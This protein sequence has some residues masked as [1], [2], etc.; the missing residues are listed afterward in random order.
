MSP[1]FGYNFGIVKNENMRKFTY[2]YTEIIQ[3]N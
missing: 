2:D 1:I 3:S